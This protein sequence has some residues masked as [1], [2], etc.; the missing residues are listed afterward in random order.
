M[1]APPP[2]PRAERLRTRIILPAQ[3]CIYFALA[4]A[5]CA[6]I[7]QSALVTLRNDEPRLDTTGQII[8]AGDGCITYDAF[9]ARYYLWGMRYQPCPEPDDKCYAGDHGI[10]PCQQWQEVPAGQC[11][12]WRNMTISVRSTPRAA[13]RA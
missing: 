9:T 6:A 3:P 4:A 7:A 10:G 2:R 11:C 1:R 5:L 8:E 12:G 13:Q